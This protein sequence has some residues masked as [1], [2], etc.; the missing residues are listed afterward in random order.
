MNQNTL[1]PKDFKEIRRFA[2]QFCFQ[3]D[4]HQVLE[5]QKNNFDLFVNQNQVEDHYRTFLEHLLRELFQKL[6]DI[7]NIL[8]QHSKN[9]PLSRMNKVD[10]AILRVGVIELISRLDTD[11][12]IIVSE[13]TELA[14]N[15][16]SSFSS[17]FVNGI[18]DSIAK[19]LR[20]QSEDTQ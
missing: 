11:Y 10:L 12:K 6:P 8:S 7:N 14:K 4:C 3:E 18:L 1:K 17:S 20:P 9:W 13:S 16:G 15:F 19:S 2:F 5:F